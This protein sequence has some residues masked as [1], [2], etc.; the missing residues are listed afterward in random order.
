MDPKWS[1]L[2]QQ[3][4]SSL[5]YVRTSNLETNQRKLNVHLT[6]HTEF[7]ALASS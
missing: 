7:Q 2:D 5:I 1:G 3:P 6:N 4:T